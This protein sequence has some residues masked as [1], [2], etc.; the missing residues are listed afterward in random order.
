MEVMVRAV[1]VQISLGL[2]VGL[3]RVRVHTF[4]IYDV[5]VPDQTFLQMVCIGLATYDDCLTQMKGRLIE[6]GK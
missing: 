3:D 4:C 6:I 2:E 1:V 5:K